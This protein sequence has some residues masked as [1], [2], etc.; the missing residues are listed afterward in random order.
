MSPLI[1]S[2]WQEL[3]FQKQQAIE[4]YQEKRQATL[5]FEQYGKALDKMLAVLWSEFFLGSKL[6]LLAT[7][8][9]GR[10]EMYPQ[11][12]LDLA[13]VSRDTLSEAEQENIAAFIQTLW[14]MQL[15]PAVKSGSLVQLCESA[16]HDLTADTAFL[17]A[18]FVC[19][20]HLLAE[21]MLQKLN[22]QRNPAAF[23][24]GKILEMQQR[25][26]KQQG[27]GAVLEPNVKTCPGGLRDIHTMLWLAKVQ[28]IQPDINSLINKR[29]L[30]RAEAGILLNSHKKL[31]RIRMDLHLATGREEDRLIFDLQSQIAP[32]LASADGKDNAQKRS[33]RVMYG[34][35][36][37]TKAIKQLNG[38]I[39]P[40][41]RGRVYSVL[42]RIIKEIDQDYYQVGSQIAV[43]DKDI[44][45]KQPE[46]IFKII[47]LVQTRHDITNIAPKTLRAWWIATQKINHKFYQN[48]LNRQ[49]FIQF[50]RHGRG[51]THTMR[52]LNLY[53]VLG[54]YLPAWGKIV[55]LLQ[56][57]LFHIYPV[58]D[59]ILMVLRNMRRLAMEQHLHELPFSSS[60]MHDFEKKEILYL[61]ALFHD[62]AKGRG[63]D[64]AIE[65]IA[66][67]EQFARD[68]F[69]SDEERELLAWLVEDH[70][71]MSMT[72]QKEDIQNPEVI[73]RFCQRVQNS[74][75]LKALY[76]LTVSD[77]R[78]TNP[79]IWNSWKANLLESL[80][81]AAE[82]YFAGEN[83]SAALVSDRRQHLAAE[84]LSQAGFS[85]KQQR[86]VW[87]ALGAAYFVRH[88]EDEIVWHCLHLAADV[89][90]AT[91]QIRPNAAMRTLQVMV[92]L[93]NAPRIFARLCR[94]FSRNQL[95]IVAARVFVSEHD[96]V[97]DTFIVQ[98]PEHCDES[99]F[100]RIQNKI[101]A[102]L[103]DFIAGKTQKETQY[104][105]KPSR[106]ARHL[107]LAPVVDL[108]AESDMPHW[109]TLN[110]VAVNRP[111]LLAD[112]ADVFNQH[113]ISLRYAK[114]NTLD[115]RVE[116]S[117]LLFSNH[118]ENANQQLELKKALLEQL[119]I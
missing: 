9:Y 11:S 87:Q 81:K 119:A 63:G 29:I 114:I 7:G 56:H 79:K 75:R 32:N 80:F 111:Y 61:A 116:D 14:D 76:L 85:P 64:H 26:D 15:A 95:D 67:A 40:M 6:C 39:V 59:H 13:I 17:E 84:A 115:E 3:R 118:L 38:I 50:F 25:H 83:Q 27:S 53:G 74:E 44:F 91:V 62:I 58:D 66:D 108:V 19:G 107:P 33:E 65:G 96:Y 43:R 102:D 52:F 92:Y 93:P 46:H 97:L 69:F 21:Q 89:E 23:I 30:T 45:Q 12:D 99:D 109:Y 2:A 47:E 5:F 4:V 42:P 41:L 24:E 51:L 54:H 103:E 28:G 110:I 18:R 90:A 101:Q 36:R 22:Q 48:P 73:A 37:A 20:N 49:R 98:M 117:F 31:S 8:G 55:G 78:G 57:D 72:A 100:L 10:E 34:F 86:R 82:R 71:L 112:I 104:A 70:L 68:H 1:Q 77:I 35:Y 106:R 105:G 113:Q 94:L 88:E 60:L 16:R